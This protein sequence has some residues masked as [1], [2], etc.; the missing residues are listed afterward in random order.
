MKIFSN[1]I[2]FSSPFLHMI[3]RD[4]ARRVMSTESELRSELPESLMEELLKESCFRGYHGYS[5]IWD[6]EIGEQVHVVCLRVP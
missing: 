6:A 2:I 4:A 3:A 1:E 5:A